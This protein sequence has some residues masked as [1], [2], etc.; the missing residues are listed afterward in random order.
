MSWVIYQVFS[1]P[2]NITGSVV[3]ALGIVVGILTPILVFYQWMRAYD[4][5]YILNNRKLKEFMNTLSKKGD[6]E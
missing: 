5:G 2:T 4:D 6:K 1:D 3:G